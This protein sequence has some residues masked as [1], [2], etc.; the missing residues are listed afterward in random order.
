MEKITK[1]YNVYKFE[2]LEKDIQEKLIN[3]EK[4]DEFDEYIEWFLYDDLYEEAKRILKE[5][6]KDATLKN[7]NYS[8]S[9]CQGDGA[10]MEFEFYYYNNLINVKHDGWYC[11]SRCFSIDGDYYLTEKQQE[12]LYNKV[13]KIQEEFE[14]RAWKVVDYTPSEEEAIEHLKEN[15]YLIDGSIFE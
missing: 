5:N 1:E 11:H 13:L 14:K 12:K 8:L 6:I 9:Y 15:K 3:Q 4:Q 2:E 7:I 10:M